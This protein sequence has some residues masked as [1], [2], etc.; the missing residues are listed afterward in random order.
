MFH[1]SMP[2][3]AN[4]YRTVGMLKGASGPTWKAMLT[5]QCTRQ[6]SKRLERTRR[7][8]N[9]GKPLLRQCSGCHMSFNRRAYV[10]AKMFEAVSGSFRVKVFRWTKAAVE[11]G[12]GRWE[13]MGTL[14]PPAR[15]VLFEGKLYDKVRSALYCHAMTWV[16]DRVTF[17]SHMRRYDA[18]AILPEELCRSATM[19]ACHDCL[20]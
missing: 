7:H 1:T 9:H 16:P 14:R 8:V 13:P 3:E 5:E 11:G 20:L 2:L 19:R 12:K 4:E 10:I 18:F 17:I 15:K 6:S